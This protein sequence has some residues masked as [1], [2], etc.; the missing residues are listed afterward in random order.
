MW[1]FRGFRLVWD[2]T[3]PP[4]SPPCWSHNSSVFIFHFNKP[5]PDWSSSVEFQSSSDLRQPMIDSGSCYR[6]NKKLGIWQ[7]GQV[8]ITELSCERCSSS[9]CSVASVCLLLGNYLSQQSGRIQRWSSIKT[10]WHGGIADGGLALLIIIS[11]L[12]R[13][14]GGG[15]RSGCDQ[16]Q[17][18][19]PDSG[20]DVGGKTAFVWKECGRDDKDEQIA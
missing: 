18:K 6:V 5:P 2:R 10:G 19:Q 12:S 14:S 11:C 13:G 1:W 4:V 8:P 20:F 9:S 17:N 16:P 15:G 7:D 3:M